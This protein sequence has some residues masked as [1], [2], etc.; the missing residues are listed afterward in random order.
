MT[1]G[2]KIHVRS[3]RHEMSRHLAKHCFKSFGAFLI[4]NSS[5]VCLYLGHPPSFIYISAQYLNSHGEAG[6]NAMKRG[7]LTTLNLSRYEHLN[8][9][10]INNEIPGYISRVMGDEFRMSILSNG[11]L[12]TFNRDPRARRR[13][14]PT[15]EDDSDENFGEMSG[16]DD[17]FYSDEDGEEENRFR[18]MNGQPGEVRDFFQI[19]ETVRNAMDNGENMEGGVD[20]TTPFLQLF[21]PQFRGQGGD[22]DNEEDEQDND[23]NPFQDPENPDNDEPRTS[24]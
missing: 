8:R 23:A 13:V 7:D 18:N 14:P 9:L 19:F 22:G 4:P 11:F 20:L 16:E 12:F 17:D 3:D 15:N 1:C 2:V 6:R 21:G 24:W 10:W 5:E